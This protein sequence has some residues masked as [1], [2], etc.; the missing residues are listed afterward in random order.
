MRKSARDL[1]RGPEGRLKNTHFV[2]QPF[3][4][5]FEIDANFPMYIYITNRKFIVV[6]F[7]LVEF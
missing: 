5:K 6:C 3:A 4:P 1:G 2:C 7:T